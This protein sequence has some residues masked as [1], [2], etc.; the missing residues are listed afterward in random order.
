MY[1]FLFKDLPSGD[2]LFGDV[3][4]DLFDQIPEALT[5]AEVKK[6]KNMLS[7][8]RNRKHSHEASVGQSSRNR[9]HSPFDGKKIEEEGISQI[10]INL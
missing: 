8:S 10:D 9:D 7:R 4:K 5:M 3:T 2:S 1:R 6:H